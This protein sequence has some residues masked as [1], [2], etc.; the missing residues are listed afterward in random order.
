ML[1]RQTFTRTTTTSSK[2]MTAEQERDLWAKFD[3]AMTRM[4]SAMAAM[5]DVFKAAFP[6]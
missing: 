3:V 6:K 1:K 4:D 2:P 5:D